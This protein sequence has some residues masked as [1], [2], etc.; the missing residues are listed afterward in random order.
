MS[1][2][3][4]ARWP[5]VAALVVLVVS[6]VLTDRIG[7]IQSLWWT[8]RIVLAAFALAGFLVVL[9]FGWAL[10][11]QPAEQRTTA[12]WLLATVLAGVACTWSDWGL[13]RRRDPE[14]FRFAFW[15]ACQMRSEVAPLA[16]DMM[17]SWNADAILLTDP[18]SMFANGGSQRLAEAGYTIARPGSFAIVSRVPII[19]ARP[20]H[21][22]RSQKLARIRL[23]TARGPLVI[24][25]IDLPSETTLH[26]SLVMRNFAAAIEDIRGDEPH[27]IAG[28]FNI[29]RGSASLREVVGDA[30]EAFAAAGEGWGGTYSR[31]TPLFAIDQTFVRAPWRPVWSRIVDPGLTRHRAQLVDLAR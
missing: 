10:R 12:K 26:R 27:L 6:Q 15:N 7:W 22:A 8:P 31:Q 9:S 23:E 29:T 14:A 25:A 16:V 5:F 2:R 20:V 1:L 3:K 28:D 30:V 24:D 17:L 19:E 4:V 21:E 13:P 18:G 11:W